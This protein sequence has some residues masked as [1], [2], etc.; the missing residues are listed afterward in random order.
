MLF[1]NCKSTKQLRATP[2]TLRTAKRY[3]IEFVINS[4][5]YY[6]IVSKCKTA[7]KM[8]NLNYRPDN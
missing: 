1:S 7:F 5:T 4:Q 2:K 8:A 6:D 3:G